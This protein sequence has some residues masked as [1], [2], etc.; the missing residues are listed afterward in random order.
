MERPLTWH[1]RFEGIRCER[2]FMMTEKSGD[3][4][5]IAF[6]SEWHAVRRG[7]LAI[8]YAATNASWHGGDHSIRSGGALSFVDVYPTL[9]VMCR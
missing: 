9:V 2:V 4:C 5:A 1:V 8:S 3:V 7:T 6:R